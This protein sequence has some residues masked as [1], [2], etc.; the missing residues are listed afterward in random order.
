MS[1]AHES[2][3]YLLIIQLSCGIKKKKKLGG[4]FSLIYPSSRVVQGTSV[5]LSLSV[6]LHV[7]RRNLDCLTNLSENL[8]GDN[9]RW[10]EGSELVF[11]L[12]PDPWFFGPKMG[13]G[14]LTILN[15]ET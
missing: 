11:D 3:M 14:W 7:P 5:S 4:I 2:F 6:H 10:E 8:H 12:Y 1:I 9:P 13:V 15:Y